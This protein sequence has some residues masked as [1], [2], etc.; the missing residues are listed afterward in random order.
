MAATTTRRNFLGAVTVGLGAASFAGRARAAGGGKP[1]IGLQLWSLRAELEKDLAGTLKQVKDWGIDEVESAGYYGRTAEEFAA[2]LRTAGLRCRSMHR[3]WDDLSNDFAAVLRDA[4][5]VGASTIVNP[6][7]PHD[8]SQRYAT[9]E[10][11]QKGAAAFAKWSSQ[12]K[13]AGRRFAYHTHSQ[14]FSPTPQGTLFDVLVEESG[15]DLGFE[16]DVFW[17]TYGGAD[18][19]ALMKKLPGRV[20]YTHIKDMATG[21]EPGKRPGPEA[22]VVLGTGTIDIAGIVAAGPAA[23]V[24]LHYIEDESADPVAQI[25]KSLVWYRDL[26]V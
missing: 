18:P 20:W 12:A 26:Q 21:T 17:I 8:Q 6:Y 23:G 4:E 19:V 15:P 11:I 16:F 1:P 24:E 3:G 13:A 9:R 14:E 25:P 22:N 2:A 10:E 7:L 5:T